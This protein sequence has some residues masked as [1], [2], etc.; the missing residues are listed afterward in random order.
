MLLE[1]IREHGSITKAAKAMDMSYRRAWEMVNSM[2]RQA[3]S[4]LVSLA[5]G[6]RG[7]GGAS[8]TA[9]GEKA[10]WVFWTFWEDL[11]QFLRAEEEKIGVITIHAVARRG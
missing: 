2:N 9:E 3:T 1:R 10:V 5:T 6:G 4:P 8:L 11:Q 7:G